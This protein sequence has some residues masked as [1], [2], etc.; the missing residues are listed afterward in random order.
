MLI[1]P[2]LTR[3]TDNLPSESFQL[4]AQ[5]GFGSSQGTEEHV[6]TTNL[7]LHKSRGTGLPLWVISLDLS[8]AFDTV[9]RDTLWEAL[10][11]RNMSDQLIWILDG[12]GASKKF[13]IFSGVP[14]G[15]VLSPRLFC[16][17]L[18]LAMSEWRATNPQAGIDLV[19]DMVRLLDLRFADDVPIFTNF[20]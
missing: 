15:C 16:A 20:C 9:K 12:A 7:F 13:D 4:E 3:V 17:A 14:Q 2:V 5:H 19:D 1:T 10:H 11:R 18:E 8:K 6:L